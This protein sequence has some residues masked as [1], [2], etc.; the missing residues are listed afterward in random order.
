M[1]PKR[2]CR[3]A[4]TKPRQIERS[5]FF[6]WTTTDKLKFTDW[7]Q[8]NRMFGSGE[9][10]VSPTGDNNPPPVLTTVNIVLV[11]ADLAQ[12]VALQ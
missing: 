12:V 1:L 11:L 9:I 3:A 5:G 2:L 8:V 6:Y 10:A 7:T 4:T